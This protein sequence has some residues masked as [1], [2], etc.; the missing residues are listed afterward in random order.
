M[1][2][3]PYQ[4]YN[5]NH[6]KR[7]SLQMNTKRVQHYGRG[8]QQNYLFQND[9]DIGQFDRSLLPEN[10]MEGE[11]PLVS[12]DTINPANYHFIDQRYQLHPNYVR[13]RSSYRFLLILPCSVLYATAV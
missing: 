2:H 11:L 3:T 7:A 8:N 1:Q 6:I 12:D 13:Q 10:Y 5:H 4:A 9:S